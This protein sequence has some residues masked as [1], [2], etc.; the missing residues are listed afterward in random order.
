VVLPRRVRLHPVAGGGRVSG[1]PSI[2]INSRLDLG[3]GVH[4][5]YERSRSVLPVT[6]S[7]KTPH[8]EDT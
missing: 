7:V 3:G 2:S 4:R 1:I 5:Y 8:W 6:R